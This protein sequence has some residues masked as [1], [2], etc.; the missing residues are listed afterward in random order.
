M[1]ARRGRRGTG[2]SKKLVLM[3]GKARRKNE[4]DVRVSYLLTPACIDARMALVR[5]ICE[6]LGDPEML[7]MQKSVVAA[8]GYLNRACDEDIVVE[9]GPRKRT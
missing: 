4:V 9:I 8:I 2:A 7:R 6:R 3:W 1:N 5:S